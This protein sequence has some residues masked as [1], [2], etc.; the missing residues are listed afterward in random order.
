MKNIILV[1]AFLITNLHSKNIQIKHNNL[2][3]N[4]NYEKVNNSKTIYLITHGT[5]AFNKMEIIQA[6]QELF[7]ENEKNSIAI[8][9][10][11]GINNRK[12][13]MYDCKVT[14]RHTHEDAIGEIDAWVK[15]LKKQGYKTIHLVG[16]SRGANQIAWFYFM[17]KYPEIK[18]ATLIAPQTWDKSK[19]NLPKALKKA[20]KYISI[21]KSYKI[22][23]DIDFIY[24]KKSNA[25]AK[26]VE[27]YYESRAFFDTPTILRKIKKPTL[28]FVGSK[29]KI[30]PKLASE[31]KK[32]KN[33]N[34]KTIIVKGANHYFRDLY[35][36]DLMDILNDFTN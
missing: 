21:G 19:S 34:V 20:K 31:M 24:C 12:S 28:V 6:M 36:E 16:H 15:Y 23:K 8:N 11:L 10:S 17:T 29:D 27:G 4:A 13:S 33:K 7:S 25:T 22:I 2:M 30:V 18:T 26:S 14:H 35:L 9:L 3:L 5:L 1:V 32:I